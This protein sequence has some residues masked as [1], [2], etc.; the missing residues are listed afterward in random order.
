MN[1][2]TDDEFEESEGSVFSWIKRFAKTY[3][4]CNDVIK[5]YTNIDYINVPL[6][7]VIDLIFNKK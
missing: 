5:I 3:S 7:P 2:K 4:I 1:W 6:T